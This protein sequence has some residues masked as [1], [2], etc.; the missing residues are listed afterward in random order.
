MRYRYSGLKRDTGDAVRGHVEA[1]SQEHAYHVLGDHGVVVESLEPDPE[2]TDDS[3][4]PNIETAIDKAFNASAKRVRF[5]KLA[6]NY[7][8][9]RVWVIDRQKIK[10]KVMSAVDKAVRQSQKQAEPA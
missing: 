4:S 8:G 2:P 3:P 5:D 10:R 7:A 6:K 1:E 9:K